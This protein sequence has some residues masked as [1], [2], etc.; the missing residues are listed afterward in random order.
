MQ[1][2]HSNDLIL[3]INPGHDSS[4]C[5]LDCNG[6]PIYQLEEERFNREK[7]SNFGSI[8][9]LE[10]LL[11][12]KKISKKQIKKLVYSFEL[13]NELSNQLR[14]HCYENVKKEFGL[15]V[16]EE[17]QA[18]CGSPMYHSPTSGFGLDTEFETLKDHLESLFPF[19]ETF[20]YNHH[21]CHAASAFYPSPFESAAIVVIDGA[22]RLETITIWSAS[23]KGIH[24]HKQVELP[25]SLGNFY[26]LF[27][28]FIGLEEGQTMGLAA[29]G[30]PRYEDLLYE[31]L[32]HCDQE[33]LFRFKKPLIH[34][35]DMYSE[36][37]MNLIEE[38]FGKEARHPSDQLT[39]FH[40]DVA[41]TI[42][43]ITEE[44]IIK[45][46]RQAKAIT[47]QNQLC[48]AGGVI[49]NCS[50]NG[51]LVDRAIF[52]DIWIQPSAND[53]GSS[54]GA[55]LVQY[56]KTHDLALNRWRMNSAQ[57][58]VSY[59]ASEVRFYL[60]LVNITYKV[61]EQIENDTSK[62]LVQDKVI[63]WFQGAAE[64]GPR[65]LGGRSLLANSTAM[66]NKFR[67]NS[68]KSRH[69]WR[70]FAPSILKEC[71]NAYVDS[72]ID[73]PF[74]IISTLVKSAKQNNV[75][76]ILHVDG[77]SRFQTV[78]YESSNKYYN[79]LKNYNHLAGVPLILNTSFNQNAEPI[80]QH[81]LEAIRNFLLMPIDELV[82]EDMIIK[83][84]PKISASLGEALEKCKVIALLDHYFRTDRN[85][86][87]LEPAS[88]HHQLIFS[89]LKTLLKWLKIGYEV[90]LPSKIKYCDTHL[91]KSAN[92]VSLFPL[93]DLPYIKALKK[94][95]FSGKILVLDDR[96]LVNR[97]VL[98]DFVYL[99]ERHRENI[100][101]LTCQRQT[102]L[103][104]YSK[105]EEVIL[106]YFQEL[107][108]DVCTFELA[109]E[110]S[111]SEQEDKILKQ[112]LE[113]KRNVFVIISSNIMSN[114][115]KFVRKAF[116]CN[117]IPFLVWR[118]FN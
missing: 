21:L 117:H 86:F 66:F 24:L 77:T 15:R 50:A 82:I 40:A 9:S 88:S 54:L 32:V 108:L 31:E 57:L 70:P 38:V 3:G 25:H 110:D 1:Q 79:L 80:V 71:Y 14:E 104:C 69:T 39:Q 75:P 94:H 30:M 47:K 60:D 76:A 16:F 96:M 87:I 101:K 85:T 59:S 111:P 41:A 37:A 64:V 103:W 98:R 2:L 83:T 89:R 97:V 13:E 18:Y 62:S 23:K 112:V 99:V 100:L 17:I 68:I 52:D 107:K 8:Y 102:L 95:N 44:C 51:K 116:Q 91:I 81:P 43:K 115:W 61:S 7:H 33:T 45:I 35:S 106:T 114:H 84:K 6:F 72:S 10:Y 93:Q 28:N 73:S 49:Q 34:W 20:S 29:Y 46:V 5:L 48:L 92:I 55:A 67:L 12:K 42:Q 113:I 4:F 109:D 90:V 27:S 56:Y 78:S 105:E 22:G 74:M 53:G 63:A 58:G 11:D 118:V 65:S 19:A 36:Y 26:W